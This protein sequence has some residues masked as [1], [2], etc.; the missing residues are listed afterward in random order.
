MSAGLKYH[1]FFNDDGDYLETNIPAPER[2]APKYI[3]KRYKNKLGSYQKSF[4]ISNN[5]YKYG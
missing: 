4:N 1:D 2:D 3:K 5:T